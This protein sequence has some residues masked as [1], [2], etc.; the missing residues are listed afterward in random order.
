MDW[1]HAIY[2]QKLGGVVEMPPGKLVAR[3]KL[4][5]V[6]L[7]SERTESGQMDCLVI[8][9]AHGNT[10]TGKEGL[11]IGD[12][13]SVL[14]KANR[15]FVL[16]A[17]EDAICR[18]WLDDL[19]VERLEYVGAHR[20]SPSGNWV[21][22]YDSN[23]V[24]GRSSLDPYAFRLGEFE[25]CA[26][27]DR[28]MLHNLEI[29]DFGNVWCDYIGGQTE[30]RNSIDEIDY[31]G[32]CV[33]K[34]DSNRFCR[35]TVPPGDQNLTQRYCAPGYRTVHA[36]LEFD[37]SDG[38]INSPPLAHLFVSDPESDRLVPIRHEKFN[39]RGNPHIAC[40]VGNG[41]LP[42]KH[43]F[44]VAGEFVWR[45]GT[46]PAIIGIN[47][48]DLD[49]HGMRNLYIEVPLVSARRS[50]RTLCLARAVSDVRIEPYAERSLLRNLEPGDLPPDLFEALP[51]EQCRSI[52][53]GFLD[54]RRR[55]FL[56]S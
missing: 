33:W 28:L 22:Y 39:A 25:E 35:L 16:I 26:D 6:W 20:I 51:D 19:E 29:D 11:F 46:E 54:W 23:V 48:K 10:I 1:H 36:F 47:T 41:W 18:V 31:L 13:S 15:E 17:R 5:S 32:N 24:Y 27:R 12:Y 53:T 52:A 21:F 55:V 50:L 37:E 14:V 38:A 43:E 9:D 40:F 7:V 30:I 8:R 2:A 49:W 56:W 34:R 4:G 45:L 42:F 3:S 44:D